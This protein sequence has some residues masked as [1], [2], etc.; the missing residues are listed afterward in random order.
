[1]KKFIFLLV[2]LLAFTSALHSPAFAGEWLGF[3]TFTVESSG[4]EGQE[5]SYTTVLEYR[6]TDNIM[7]DF[8]L[9]KSNN[10]LLIDLS[11]TIYFINQDKIFTTAG[12]RYPFYNK[13]PIYYL[14]VTYRF[15]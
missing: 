1:M 11:G 4:D 12:V 5:T 6:F 9:E 14:S 8:V 10:G 15:R 13:D 7:T 3:Q 2:L